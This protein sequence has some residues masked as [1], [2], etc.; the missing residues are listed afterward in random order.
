MSVA[1]TLAKLN[2]QK[3]IK[4]ITGVHT[5]ETIEQF[6]A[7]LLENIE[8]NRENLAKRGLSVADF[9]DEGDKYTIGTLFWFKPKLKAREIG[10]LNVRSGDYYFVPEGSEEGVYGSKKGFTFSP[11]LTK[12]EKPLL[13]DAKANKGGLVSFEL[14]D[15]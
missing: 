10:I 4:C 12:V 2:G 6:K 7:E 15:K 11:D 3:V 14:V 5:V 9:K 8:L 1:K 13:A